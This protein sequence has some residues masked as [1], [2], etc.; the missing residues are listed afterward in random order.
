MK[1][2]WP[3]E[4]LNLAFEKM[5]TNKKNVKEHMRH[6][7]KIFYQCTTF[8][9]IFS[10]LN[11]QNLMWRN[12]L[13]ILWWYTMGSSFFWRI[14]PIVNL[15]HLRFHKLYCKMIK[16]EEIHSRETEGTYQYVSVRMILKKIFH[17]IVM[18][19]LWPDASKSESVDC[20]FV[21]S[22]GVT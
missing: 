3:D 18:I 16:N 6:K 13:R 15:M 4:N 2:C 22:K 8:Q 17:L 5:K 19:Q 10:N 1:F 21:K 11:Q 14:I 12:F 9:E 20:Y 7:S